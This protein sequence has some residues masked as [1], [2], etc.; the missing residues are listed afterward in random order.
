MEP[1]DAVAASMMPR[2]AAGCAV[3]G[4]SKTISRAPLVTAIERRATEVLCV[5]AGTAWRRV[6][7]EPPR[8]ESAKPR[9]RPQERGAKPGGCD[10]AAWMAY[11]QSSA[12]DAVSPARVTPSIT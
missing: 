12:D 4:F 1:S 6:G 3:I 7:W 5:D 10:H 2:M 9:S 11:F 8:W